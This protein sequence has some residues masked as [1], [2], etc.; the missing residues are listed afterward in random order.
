[1]LLLLFHAI[2]FHFPERRKGEE[3]LE[4]KTSKFTKSNTPP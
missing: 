1:M 4:A 2:V 3:V